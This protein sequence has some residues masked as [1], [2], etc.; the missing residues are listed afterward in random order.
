MPSAVAP[1]GPTSAQLTDPTPAFPRPPAASW[2]GREATPQL[3]RVYGTAWP[4]REARKAP[5]RMLAEAARRDH[6]KLGAD[7]VNIMDVGP[8]VLDLYGVPVPDYCDGK[9]LA[10]ET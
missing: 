7:R 9:P 4:T 5:L 2:R 1:T 3:Q 6:R 10:V 8:T